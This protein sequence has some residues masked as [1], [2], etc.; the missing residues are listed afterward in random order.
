MAQAK[1]TPSD[2]LPALNAALDRLERA[3]HAPALASLLDA[4]RACGDG[5]IADA[6]DRLSAIVTETE[7]PIVAVGSTS[8]KTAWYQ[9]CDARRPA[10][11]GRLLE[12]LPDGIDRVKRLEALLA[13]P[14]DP[15]IGSAAR[16]WIEAP[17]VQGSN[18]PGFFNALWKLIEHTRDARLAPVIARISTSTARPTSV[19]AF[20]LRSWVALTELAERFEQLPAPLPLGPDAIAA[21]S[22]VEA[23]LAEPPPKATGGTSA[24]EDD[25]YARIYADPTDDEPRAVLADLLL[26]RGDPRGE[27]IALQMGRHGTDRPATPAERKLVQQW[28]RTWLGPL[29]DVL[30][31]EGVEYERGF[32]ARCR[33]AGGEAAGAKEWMTVTHL[34][35]SR[36]SRYVAGSSALFRS[37]HLRH[38]R[39]VTGLSPADLPTLSARGELPWETVGWRAWGWDYLEPIA[40]GAGSLFAAARALVVMQVESHAFTVPTEAILGILS[41]WPNIEAFTIGAETRHVSTILAS[42]RGEKLARLVVIDPAMTVTVER[43]KLTIALRRLTTTSVAEVVRLMRAVEPTS[44]AVHGDGKAA[45]EDG[46]TLV[47]KSARAS[48]KPIVDAAKDAGVPLDVQGK[49]F[50]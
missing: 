35:V 23:R 42:E 12:A 47:M 30:L 4:W 13:W 8:A 11:L 5:R 21:A 38:V 24:D 28:G 33:F 26:Q 3:E 17:P 48:M 50:S 16:A 34:D 18:R 36:A 6:I 49:S 46:P 25:L 2:P 19:N 40:K 31:K 39:H 20:G 45:L 32:L 29:D 27:F 14:A 41:A 43:R 7:K 15:R 37:P 22:R 9:A 44:V 10:A 1:R